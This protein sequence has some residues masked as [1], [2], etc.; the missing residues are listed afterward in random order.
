MLPVKSAELVK[1]P[2]DPVDRA[3]YDKLFEC[4]SARVKALEDSSG[5]GKHFSQVLALLLRLRQACCATALLPQPLLAELRQT[6]DGDASRVLA[7]AVTALGAARV[8]SILQNLAAA[9]EDDCSICMVPGCDVVTRCGHIFH[10]GCLEAVVKEL[11]KG[12][13][14]PCPLCRQIVRKSEILE[15]PQELEIAEDERGT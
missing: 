7:A 1:V 8:E 10:R 6:G 15:K 5:L 4:A 9:Q 2:L 3:L 12:G 11:G 14:A 13:S